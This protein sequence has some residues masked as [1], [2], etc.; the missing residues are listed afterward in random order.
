MLVKSRLSHTTASYTEEGYTEPA[1]EKGN[2]LTENLTLS[3]KKPHTHQ[4]VSLWPP[5]ANKPVKG[6]NVALK[7]KGKVT[8]DVAVITSDSSKS[9]AAL[10]S[11]LGYLKDASLGNAHAAIEREGLAV[12]GGQM[13]IARD[14]SR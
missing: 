11:R 5:K 10:K 12:S 2:K 9:S 3:F 14:P 6:D 1:A 7:S 8:F 13:E 4:S